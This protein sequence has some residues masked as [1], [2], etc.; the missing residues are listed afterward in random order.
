M[1]EQGLKTREEIAPEYK[2]AIEDLYRDDDQWREDYEE[3]KKRIPKMAEFQ[4][5]LG[6]SA[7]TLLLKQRTR[8]EQNMLAQKY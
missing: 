8:D 7:Q 6:E 4:G 5:R 2:W 1:A 3:L